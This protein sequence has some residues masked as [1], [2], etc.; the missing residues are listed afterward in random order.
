MSAEV[1]N[2]SAV[3][4]MPTMMALHNVELSVSHETSLLA[5]LAIQREKVLEADREWQ[6]IKAHLASA[7]RQQDGVLHATTIH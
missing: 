3:D 5:M 6:D 2:F 4:T 7:C 1:M